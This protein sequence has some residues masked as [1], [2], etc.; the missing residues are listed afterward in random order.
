M[1][2]Q[3]E[4]LAKI[5]QVVQMG[6]MAQTKQMVQPLRWR[7]GQRSWMA[8]PQCSWREVYPF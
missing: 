7:L 8:F 1:A 6:Q 5:V 3:T 4:Q 2:R